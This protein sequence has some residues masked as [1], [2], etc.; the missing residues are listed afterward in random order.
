MLVGVYASGHQYTVHGWS[1][2]NTLCM[3]GRSPI[4]CAWLVGHPIHCAWLVGHQYTVHGWS[5]IQYTVHGWSVINVHGWSVINTLC[6]AGRS[7]IHCAWLVGHQY[8]VHGWSVINTLCMAG[9][10]PIHCAWLV[11]HLAF[12]FKLNCKQICHVLK[13]GLIII[14][15]LHYISIKHPLSNIKKTI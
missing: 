13:I 8:T 10:S 5:V 3:A 2:I 6:M 14:C 12:I 15:V 4:H 11:G 9:R 1:V 7:S